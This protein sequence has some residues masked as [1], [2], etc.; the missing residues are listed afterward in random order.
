[1]LKALIDPCGA[2]ICGED[3]QCDQDQAEQEGKEVFA[4]EDLFHIFLTTK[5][6]KIH[7]GRDLKS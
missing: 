6:T 1:M 3:D 7:K 5:V 4:G 2:A